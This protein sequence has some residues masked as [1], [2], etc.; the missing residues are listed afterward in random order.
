M[1]E[2]FDETDSIVDNFNLILIENAQKSATCISNTR[3]NRNLQKKTKMK[4]LFSESYTDLYNSVKSYEK[5]VNKT[6]LM[7]N[8]ENIFILFVA[9]LNDDVN[10]KKKCTSRIFTQN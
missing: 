1:N 6:L 2:T 9:G 7:Q 10:M 4:P 3:K 8:V 5:L